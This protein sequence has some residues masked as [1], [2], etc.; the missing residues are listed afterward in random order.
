ME[1][2]TNKTSSCRDKLYAG[3]VGAFTYWAGKWS[4]G[5]EDNTKAINP[6]AKLVAIAPIEEVGSYIERQSPVLAITSK[7]ENPEGV[8]KYL[9][10]YMLDGAEG[11][12]LFTYGVEGT[13]YEVKDGI[14]TQLPNL[15]NPKNLFAS[16]YI[17]PLLSIS[18]WV[19]KDPLADS[20]DPR[21]TETNDIFMSHSKIAPMVV[22]N[23]AMAN[24]ASSLLDIRTV[25][26]A[27]VV[28][29]D[30]SVEDGLNSYKEQTASMVD[31]ILSSL[32][33]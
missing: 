2:T 23:D 13:H 5:L 19:D 33:S 3:S 25:I 27:D 28:T 24:Y 17:D 26:V 20:R 1:I 4:S 22:T 12:M 31:E 21:V 16:A 7:C 29:G 32:N 6:D 15:E 9:F 18:S 10:D 30:M 8:Y 11:Q 14:Y